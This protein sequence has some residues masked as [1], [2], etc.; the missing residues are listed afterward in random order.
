LALPYR[1]DYSSFQDGARR[2]Q[3]AMSGHNMARGFMR[4]TLG[5]PEQGRFF[6][7]TF[8]EY[9]REIMGADF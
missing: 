8:R 7:E 4:V 3:A 9:C 6:V 1:K 2:F 5:K